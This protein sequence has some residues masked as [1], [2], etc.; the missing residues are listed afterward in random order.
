MFL[1]L[2]VTI[3][4]FEVATESGGSSEDDRATAPA[5]TRIASARAI[6]PVPARSVFA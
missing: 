2:M 5:V 3:R 6:E 4:W 1:V